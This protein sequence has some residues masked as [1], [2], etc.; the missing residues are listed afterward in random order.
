MIEVAP[1]NPTVIAELAKLSRDPTFEERLLRGV[2]DDCARLVERII[3]AL[4]ER[5]Y[6]DLG[7]AA[8]ALKGAAVLLSRL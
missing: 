6:E 2:R 5:N 7:D 3:T 4:A 1:L 8:H